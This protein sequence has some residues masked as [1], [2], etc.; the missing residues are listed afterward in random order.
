M[1]ILQRDR[2]V[3]FKEVKRPTGRPEHSFFLTEAGHE[4]LPKNYD[5][6]LDSLFQ[7]IGS[8]EKED[9]EG[10]DGQGLMGILLSRI[11]QRIADRAAVSPNDDLS[12]RAATLAS[13]L[14][15]EQFTPRVELK[16]GSIQIE[17]FNCPFRSVALEHESI[18]AFDSHLISRVL[19]TQVSLEKCVTWGDSSCFYVAPNPGNPSK[20]AA[21]IS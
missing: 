9:V 10:Q 19:G 1:D 16:N 4:V 14:E 12:Q 7:E 13:L 2:L 6:L 11:A 18:C 21:A 5:R 3:S 17:L 8:L 15:E 20:A